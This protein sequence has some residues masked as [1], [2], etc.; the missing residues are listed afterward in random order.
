MFCK[1]S[2]KTSFRA[3]LYKHICG[4]NGSNI[5]PSTRIEEIVLAHA[6]CSY[7]AKALFG[8]PEIPVF[9]LDNTGI[10]LLFCIALAQAEEVMEMKL[11]LIRH[12]LTQENTRHCYLGCRTDVP[13]CTEGIRLAEQRAAALSVPVP[14]L[15]LTSPMQRCR[16]TAKILFPDVPRLAVNGLE[17]CDFGAWEGKTYE[18][19]SGDPAYQAWIDSGGTLPFPG[20]ESREQFTER[21]CNAM[22]QALQNRTEGYLAAVVHGGTIMALLSR[23]EQQQLSYFA[24][25]IKCCQSVL[26]TVTERMPLRLRAEMPAKTAF[27]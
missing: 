1:F 7:F 13:L 5:H 25:Q 12:S 27:Q 2:A 14:E 22:E 23:L 11:L 26:C 10:L 6:L 9:F 16:E 15:V 24:W 19:L 3:C 8:A 17:E 18:M 4:R 20:G 21:C